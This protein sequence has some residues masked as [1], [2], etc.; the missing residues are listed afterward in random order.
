MATSRPR[1]SITVT[2]EIADVLRR[3]SD[4][5]GETV[6]SIVCQMLE[7]SRGALEIGVDVIA[8]TK[9]MEKSVKDSLLLALEPEK[10]HSEKFAIDTLQRMRRATQ[11]T[12][13]DSAGVVSGGASREA[14][15][16]S[17]NKG[18]RSTKPIKN[19]P[20]QPTNVQKKSSSVW[21]ASSTSEPRKAEPRG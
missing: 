17:I 2:A 21:L 15:P 3:F 7:Q 14:N 1:L 12:P 16:L 9:A 13:S 8:N 20:N 6:S 18:V 5:S 19:P 10:A 11:A 4:V